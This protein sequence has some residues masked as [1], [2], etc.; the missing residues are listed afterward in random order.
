MIDGALSPSLPT[1][2]LQNFCIMMLAPYMWNLKKKKKKKKKGKLKEKNGVL[3]FERWKQGKV[4][5]FDLIVNTWRHVMSSSGAVSTSSSSSGS[6][7]EDESSSP[8]SG[9]AIRL[10]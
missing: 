8:G 4:S 5:L 1:H 2:E 9:I 6:A 10:R 3:L 7:E